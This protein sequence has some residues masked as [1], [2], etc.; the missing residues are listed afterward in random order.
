ME[1]KV[2]NRAFA[3]RFAKM[4]FSTVVILIIAMYIGS[5]FFT[6]IDLGLYGYMVGTVVFIGGF[7]LSLY[8]MGGTTASQVDYKKRTALAVSQKHTKNLGG[9]LGHLS[10]YMEPRCLSL[11]AACAARLGLYT[12]FFRD[13]PA[14]IR[15]DV[16]YDGK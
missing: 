10:F 4:Y 2:M 5:R 3:S 1:D 14:C 12:I 13:F 7:F 8:R 6:H 15:L 9:A 16:L 11:D